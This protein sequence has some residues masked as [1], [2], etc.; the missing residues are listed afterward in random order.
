MR[1]TIPEINLTD[2]K[3]STGK[4]FPFAKD[5]ERNVGNDANLDQV[6][7]ETSTVLE[8]FATSSENKY[9]FVRIYADDSFCERILKKMN[10][11]NNAYFLSLSNFSDTDTLMEFPLSTREKQQEYN[12]F[13]RKI[14]E[15]PSQNSAHE[16]SSIRKID[17]VQYS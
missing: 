1:F 7:D 4:C 14:A 5:S 10:T 15:Y 6:I 11:K 16:N 9:L 13:M 12:C 17:S 8:E 3:L 2:N